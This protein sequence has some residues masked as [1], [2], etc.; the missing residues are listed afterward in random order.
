MSG[1]DVFLDESCSPLYGKLIW[2][3]GPPAMGW[4][5]WR[6][7]EQGSYTLVHGLIVALMDAGYIEHKAEST[8]IRI[9]YE[10]LHGAGLALAEAP[11]ATKLQV[12]DECADVLRR[13]LG[14][15]RSSNNASRVR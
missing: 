10:L 1:L 12:R 7:F 6:D 3:E 13:V 14:G 11:Q 15:L 4:R 8:T 2:Q 5:G 9:C